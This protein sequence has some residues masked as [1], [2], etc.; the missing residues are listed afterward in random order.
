MSRIKTIGSSMK[1]FSAKMRRIP[2]SYRTAGGGLLLAVLLLNS[3]LTP[4]C[5]QRV[6]L[7]T[8]EFDGFVFE[9]FEAENVRFEPITNPSIQPALGYW[10]KLGDEVAPRWDTFEW[11]WQRKGEMCNFSDNTSTEDCKVCDQCLDPAFI[12]TGPP[13]DRISIAW[14]PGWV[15]VVKDPGFIS[16]DN[17]EK[18]FDYI[19]SPGSVP[20]LACS[21]NSSPPVFTPETSGRYSIRSNQ[22]FKF[23]GATNAEIKLYVVAP[24]S[25]QR[26]PYQLTGK[27][28]ENVNDGNGNIETHEYWTWTMGGDPIWLENFSPNLRVTNVRIFKGICADGSA[29]GKQCAVPTESVPVRPSRVFFL[30]N[31]ANQVDNYAGG[32]TQYRCYSAPDAADGIEGNFINLISCRKECA[33]DAA[34]NTCTSTQAETRDVVPTYLVDSVTGARPMERLTWVVE[35]NTNEGA[36]A[37]LTTPGNNPMPS[38]AKLIIEFTIQVK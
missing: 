4:G 32:T 14:N 29:Q 21:G 10:L 5:L 6:N 22:P 26:T 23:I 27:L 17:P 31:F 25:A 18:I 8:A 7:T 2:L 9:E 11:R 24:D 28:S 19:Q 37:D 3:L 30:A 12:S 33:R 34:T 1:T 13:C 16:T 35:F 15:E 38:D 36:D 20:W